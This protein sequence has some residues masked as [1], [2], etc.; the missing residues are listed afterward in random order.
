MRRKTVVFRN[1]A[2]G[3]VDCLNLTRGNLVTDDTKKEMALTN[4]NP[5]S[6][7]DAP[8]KEFRVPLLDCDSVELVSKSMSLA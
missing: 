2:V 7:G 4:S 1:A 8:T 5:K 6:S 3:F